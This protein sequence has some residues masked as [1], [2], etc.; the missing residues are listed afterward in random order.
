MDEKKEE[1]KNNNKGL[2]YAYWNNRKSSIKTPINKRPTV[3]SDEG[4]SDDSEEESGKEE[5]ESEGRISIENNKGKFTPLQ[6]QNS[7]TFK[8]FTESVKKKESKFKNL[9]W[10]E[11]AMELDEILLIDLSQELE[12]IETEV[13]DVNIDLKVIVH[14]PLQSINYNYNKSHTLTIQNESE[15]NM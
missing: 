10:Y 9:P 6:I 8:E 14:T 12:D 2:M 11:E 13:Y 15:E 3:L 5:E 1:E 4:I 7:T